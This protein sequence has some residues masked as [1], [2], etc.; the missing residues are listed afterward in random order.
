MADIV[1]KAPEDI[2]ARFLLDEA[3]LALAAGPVEAGPGGG[4]G[5]APADAGLDAVCEQNGTQPPYLV[6]G[7][8]LEAAAR[9]RF[10]GDRFRASTQAQVA[11]RVAPD[12]PR[13][14]A[15]AA[16]LLAQQG[17]VD[18]ADAVLARAAHFATLE[19][20]ALGWGRGSP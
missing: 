5:P 2:R 13:L 14:L 20:P 6:A 16:Q 7:C 15:R 4:P 17:A 10:G 3:S 19:A 9:A 8:A 18:R 11:A 12:E 1:V